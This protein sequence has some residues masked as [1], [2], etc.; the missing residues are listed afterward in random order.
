MCLEPSQVQETELASLE[1]FG[2]PKGIKMH[3][4]SVMSVLIYV[5][6]GVAVGF[7][8]MSASGRQA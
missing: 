6:M 1:T 7:F 8:N 3:P 2:D 4:D 5:R